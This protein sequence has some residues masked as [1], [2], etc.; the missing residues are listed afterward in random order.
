MVTS[1]RVSGTVQIYGGRYM[2]LSNRVSG[3]VQ[4][5]SEKGWGVRY[6]ADIW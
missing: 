3:T 1:D 5:Y 6:C 4:I 2:V